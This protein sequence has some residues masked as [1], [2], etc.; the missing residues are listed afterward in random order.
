MTKGTVLTVKQ[1]EKGYSI[2]LDDGEWYS[3]FGKSPVSKGDI[4]EFEFK[5]SDDGQWNNIQKIEVT[6]KA[7]PQSTQD[8]IEK[9][10][11]VLTSYAKDEIVAKLQYLPKPT[12]TQEGVDLIE[13]FWDKA[14]KHVW[15]SYNYFK[16]KL[17]GEKPKDP[18]EIAS[19]QT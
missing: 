16:E 4:V 14:N 8:K 2:N 7:V 6:D 5:V 18:E 15:K 19:I 11:G 13:A 12:E 3:G 17:K 10:I 9:T 1:R